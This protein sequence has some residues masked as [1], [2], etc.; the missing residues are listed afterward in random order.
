MPLDP[1][2]FK[3]LVESFSTEL[4]EHVQAMTSGLLALEE[5]NLSEDNYRKIIENIFRSAHNI[6]GTSYTLG[7]NKVGEIAHSI[8]STFSEI[9]KKNKVITSK[10]IDNCLNSIDTIKKAFIEFIQQNEFATA[11][12]VISNS[13]SN[14]EYDSIRVPIHKIEKISSLLEELH[15]NKIAIGKY[16]SDLNH[17]I[18]K[19]KQVSTV[20]R[21]ISL[22]NRGNFAKGVPDNI[23]RIYTA[24]NDCFIDIDK[25]TDSMHK[26]IRAFINDLSILLNAIEEEVIQLRMIPVGNLLCTFPRYVRDLSKELNKNV[27]LTL[28][29]EDVKVDKAVLEGLKDPIIH[30]LRNAIDHGI[31]PESVRKELGKPSKG[32]INIEIK[33][34]QA[35]IKIIITDD[36]AGIDVN[37]LCEIA[38][39]K[40]ILSKSE[41]ERMNEIEKLEL[42]FFSGFSTKDIITDVSGRGVGLDVVKSNIENLKGQINISTQKGKQTTFTLSVPLSIASERGLLIRSAGQLF[43]VPTSSVERVMF[44]SEDQIINV[45]GAPAIISENQTLPFRLLSDILGLTNKYSINEKKLSVMIIKRGVY[46]LAFLV[47]EI[48]GEKEIIIKSLQEPLSKIPC[49][50]GGTLLE[51]NQVIMVLDPGDLV[52]YGLKQANPTP[53]LLNNAETKEVEQKRILVVDDSITTRTLEKNILESRDYHVTV[54]VNGKEAWDILQNQKFSLLITD[55][56]MP[57]MDGFTLTDHIKKSESLRSLPVIIVT[58]IGSDAEKKRGIDVGADAYIVKNEF[59][60]GALLSIVSQLL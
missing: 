41:F 18:E 47:D 58:S 30:L 40:K 42:I 38:E 17:L 11:M 53:I 3:Q 23:Q 35:L 16:Y 59:E 7:I 12:P 26:N 39:S 46:V 9:Q 44:V 4:D 57:I 60:S 55:V 51:N 34:E 24:G 5:S 32:R 49:V 25:S 6:K 52:M 22:A 15:V 29:G 21:Q 28:T 8:E 13:D 33:E 10:D 43:V 45:Q 56:M 20:W 37:K 19:T 2:L 36:G 48:I 14:H 54:A 1:E 50:S 31:E 27:E